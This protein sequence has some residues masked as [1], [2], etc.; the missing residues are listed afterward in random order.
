[1]DRQASIGRCLSCRHAL[2][3]ASSRGAEFW[4]CRLSSRDPAFPKYP[5]LPVVECRGYEL[6]SEP[7][8]P[9]PDTADDREPF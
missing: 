8:R 2:R 5:P 9:P 4:M 1:M 3:V 6:Q 7:E